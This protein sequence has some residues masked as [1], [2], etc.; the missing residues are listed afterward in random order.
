MIYH[1]ELTTPYCS[2]AYIC[3]LLNIN[4]IWG[5]ILQIFERNFFYIDRMVIWDNEIWQFNGAKL[6][7]TMSNQTNLPIT[8]DVDDYRHLS[9]KKLGDF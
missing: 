1:A 4:A 9:R 7:V 3:S 2:R 8:S 5:E 6:V